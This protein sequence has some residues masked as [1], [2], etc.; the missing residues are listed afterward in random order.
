MYISLCHARIIYVH[1]TSLEMSRASVHL[2][3]HKR[4]LSNDTCRESLNDTCHKSLDV[5]YQC[6]ANE[7]TKT[8]TAKNFTIVIAV[9][10]QF[11]TDYV[12][13]FPSNSE[14]HHLA[15]SSLEVV[16]DKF[17]ILSSPNCCNFVPGFKHFVRSGMDTM[18]SSI[19][20]GQSRDKVFVFKCP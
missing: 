7:V 4:V 8:T 15:G 2:G 3:V 6:V 10:K 13:K 17:S 19:C 5:T 1:S 18:N 20:F 11:L 9:N 12:F 16:M 14:G